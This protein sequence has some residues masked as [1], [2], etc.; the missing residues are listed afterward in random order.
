MSV[1]SGG[2]CQGL[3]SAAP[4]GIQLQLLLGAGSFGRVYAAVWNGAR[5]AVKIICHSAQDDARISDELSLRCI[6]ATRGR[7]GGDLLG[8]S[9]AVTSDPR[10]AGWG[11]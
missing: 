3:T 8:G 9:D 7:W 1:A 4:D 10:E 6:W 2:Y 5:V 11:A